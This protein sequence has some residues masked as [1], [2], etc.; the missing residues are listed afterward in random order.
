MDESLQQGAEEAERRKDN[1]AR[2]HDERVGEVLYDDPAGVP[3]DLNGLP[4]RPRFPFKRSL[5]GA[6]SSLLHGRRHYWFV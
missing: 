2:I 6:H 4:L 1:T 3:R 5:A